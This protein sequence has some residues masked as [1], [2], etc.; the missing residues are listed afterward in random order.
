LGVVEVRGTVI[1]AS[2]TRSPRNLPASSTSLRSTCALISSGEYCLPR[3]SKRAAPPSPST[4]SKLTALA[5]ADIS[6]KRR[7][8]NRF[9][10]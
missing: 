4:T 7:P 8:M 10:E 3:T 2:F 5:S 1:T 6:S 9:A